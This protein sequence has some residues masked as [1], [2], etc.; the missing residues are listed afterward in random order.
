M[1]ISNNLVISKHSSSGRR[2]RENKLQTD[3]SFSLTLPPRECYLVEEGKPNLSFELFF[4][5]AK[6]CENRMIVT[7]IYPKILASKFKGKRRE[8]IESTPILW[9]SSQTGDDWINPLDIGIL[10]DKIVRF[11]ENSENSVILLDGI[12]YLIVNNG[13]QNVMKTIQR[14]IETVMQYN[15]RL[16]IPIEPRALE[17]NE[18]AILERD[19]EVITI[20]VEK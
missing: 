7:H 4:E 11:I 13:F 14:M 12:E 3:Y 1:V 16:I 20:G 19:M 6:R 18:L 10:V 2:G 5:V 15:S 8:I 9:L 17:G